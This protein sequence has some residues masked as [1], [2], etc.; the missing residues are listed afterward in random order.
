MNMGNNIDNKYVSNVIDELISLL[1]IKE[2][3][4]IVAIRKPFDAGNVKGCIEKIADYL[5]LPIVI[6]LSYVPANYRTRN[7]GN[8]FESS[9]LATTDRSGRGVE[10]ITAQVSIPSYLPFYG[11][12]GLQGFPISVKIS[13][14]CLRHPETFLAIMAHELSHI[15]L[16]SLL[17]KEKDNEFYTDPTAM[18]LG[19]ST[20]MKI[21]RKV[22]ETKENVFSTET[23]TTTYG[24]LSDNQFNFAFNRISAILKENIDSRKKVFEKLITYRQRLS[25]YKK[26][27]FKFKR[28]VEYLDK[29]QSKRVRREDGAKI[30]VFH[31]VDYTDKFAV[32]IRSNEAKLKEINDFCVGLVHYTQPRLNSLQKFDEEIDTLISELRSEFDLLNND[33]NTLGKYVGFFHKR[34]INRQ[35]TLYAKN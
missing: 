10:G 15:V 26:E 19:F 28:F 29:N 11:T 33:V 3:I 31:Q 25:F 22:V 16:H 18:I 17:H 4:P 1:G 12:S 34:K 35:A 27:F 23:L 6:N 7:A 2:H 13:D 14:N 24:Y 9:A 32:V 21:G 30:V 5:G 8:R 20:V